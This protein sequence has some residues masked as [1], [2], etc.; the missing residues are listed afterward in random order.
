MEKRL[1]C[2]TADLGRLSVALLMGF[3]LAVLVSSALVMAHDPEVWE[4]PGQVNPALTKETHTLLDDEAS[5]FIHSVQWI[6]AGYTTTTIPGTFTT[7]LDALQWVSET[8]TF[9]TDLATYGAGD[10][11]ANPEQTLISRTGD[12]EDQAFL[13]ASLLKWHTDEVSPTD[14]DLV[15]VNLGFSPPPTLYASVLWYDASAIAFHRF[16][17]VA[18]EEISPTLSVLPG[19]LWL[20]DDRILGFLPGYYADPLSPVGGYD[21]YDFWRIAQEGYGDAMNNY[22]WA[23]AAFKDQLYVGTGRNIPWRVLQAF[24][25]GLLDLL[26]VTQ[27]T[28]TVGTPDWAE[29]MRA[30]IW[31]YGSWEQV[32]TSPVMTTDTAFFP[33]EP[34][35]RQMV[36]FSDTLYAAIGGGFSPTVE[37]LLLKSTDG[38]HWIT[39]TTPVSMG[40]DSRAMLVHSDTLYL[41]L[42]TAPEVWAYD[43]ITWTRAGDFASRLPMTNTAVVALESFNGSL[44]A[45]TQNI[46]SGFQV[47]K[48]KDADLGWTQVISK[49]AGEGINYWAG[50]MEVFQGGLYVGSMSLPVVEGPSGGFVITR[51]KGC[52]LIRIAPD[53]SWELIVGD[54]VPILKPEGGLSFRIPRSGWPGGFG[55]FLNFYCWSL[56]EVNGVLYLGTFDASAFLRFLPVEDILTDPAFNTLTTTIESNRGE[57]TAALQLAIG[58]LE[59]LGVDEDYVRPYRELLTAFDTGDEIDWQGAWRAVTDWFAGG[60]LWKSNDGMRWRPVTLNGF[61]DPSNYGVRNM[62]HANP[63]YVGMSNPFE[64][65]EILRTVGDLALYYKFD[66]ET[67]QAT[68]ASGNDNHGIIG[69]D[70]ITVAVGICNDAFTFD[71]V[72]DYI[73]STYAGQS[74]TWTVAAWVMADAA[75]GGQG[76]SYIVNRDGNYAITWDHDAPG[77]RGTAQ[78]S[79]TGEGRVVSATFDI[80]GQDVN[81]WVHL[82]ATWDGEALRA[83][84]NCAMT[85]V[86]TPTST[87]YPSRTAELV[88][89]GTGPLAS[90]K[91]FTG[92]IDEVRVY[93]GALSETEISE[94][95]QAQVEVLKY[96]DLDLDGQRDEETEQELDGWEFV[97]Y[98]EGGVE[99]ARGET[100]EGSVTFEGLAAGQTYTVCEAVP[101]H[102]M[103]TW[104]GLGVRGPVTVCTTTGV[105][106]PVD[107][108]GSTGCAFGNLELD[109]A[110][111]GGVAEPVN[112]LALL[113]PWLALVVLL[114]VLAAGAAACRSSAV[115]RSC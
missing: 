9:T 48:T 45:G 105:L 56:Q 62:V 46:G 63:L 111:V 64:G 25:L 85:D 81:R 115:R 5:E 1:R 22:P 49:G 113:A 55:N 18:G 10:V 31:R 23:M 112:R 19:T 30:E 20:A 47:F 99:V 37:N 53:D 88:R 35:F 8:I 68:D 60:D 98:D 32:Y 34:G 79:H 95:C 83:Y 77:L 36:T 107:G 12:Y 44:Y 97:L 41:G 92:T 71:G 51:P 104:P 3:G 87:G 50:S 78:F 103:N 61:D 16:D 14:G 102:W 91:F 43:G 27:P 90:D 110:V 26:E 58:Q 29:D 6:T 21:K 40:T 57:I 72:D 17:P 67:T 65:L 86:Y 38:A 82:A 114:G 96:E 13:L 100:T 73:S 70:P 106:P 93:R 75:P 33:R 39:V 54:Y 69:G 109:D 84:K 7:A 4:G 76:P 28:S 24:P 66:G 52:E 2:T 15:Y 74:P 101:S 108:C 42:G 94:L 11:W 80:Q 89:I 59:Y